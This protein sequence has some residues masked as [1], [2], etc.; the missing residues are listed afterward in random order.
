MLTQEPCICPPAPDHRMA[1]V[2][3]VLEYLRSQEDSSD[4]SG[5]DSDDS[6]DLSFADVS[7]S[8]SPAHS[9]HADVGD[10]HDLSHTRPSFRST[11]GGTTRVRPRLEPLGTSSGRFGGQTSHSSTGTGGGKPRGAVMNFVREV[12][13]G[14]GVL[15]CAWVARVGGREIARH[16]VLTSHSRTRLRDE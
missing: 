6:Q 8:F 12:L 11:N 10:S 14:V 4:S 15:G 5:T 13:V 7:Q 3:V 2:V 1:A 16:G 9:S